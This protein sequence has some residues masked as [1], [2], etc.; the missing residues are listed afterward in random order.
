MVI[1]FLLFLNSVKATVNII[2]NQNLTLMWDTDT[3]NNLRNYTLSVNV[4]AYS[5][6]RW[7]GIGFKINT[8]DLTM[9]EADIIVFY[10]GETNKCQDR[11]SASPA[12]EPTLDLIQDVNCSD[13]RKFDN[14][15]KY[16][17]KK[18]L[19]TNDKD[20]IT[21][22]GD[23]KAE[24][25]ILWAFGDLD[26]DRKILAHGNKTYQRGSYIYKPSVPI[27]PNVNFSPN[28]FDI[29]NGFLTLFF[30]GIIF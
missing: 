15:I 24:L 8:N 30:M 11:Y 13:R 23:D 27:I 22:N 3:N 29:L 18:P 7:V 16:Y 9:S 28:S 21:L 4:S 17:W 6:N 26:F 10:M 14:E 20:D 1:T 25:N 12:T 19:R 5:D 2:L